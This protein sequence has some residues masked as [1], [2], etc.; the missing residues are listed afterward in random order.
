MTSNFKSSASTMSVAIPT[1]TRVFLDVQC[2]PD[3]FGRIVIELF[4]DKT[5]KTA[6]NFRT[7]CTTPSASEALTYKGS[8]F[9]R[10][11]DEFM[12]QGGDITTG[13]GTGGRSIYGSTF[14]DEN[15]GW[16]KIDAV[17][18]VCMANRGKDTNSSQ[19]VSILSPLKT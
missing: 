8:R 15:I 17:G 9:H 6:E 3:Y 5:P 7:I 14:D 18:L 19:Y 2:G 13:N 1:R 11:V 4:N 12:I 16:R 10:I